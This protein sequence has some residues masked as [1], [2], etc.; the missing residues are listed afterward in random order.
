MIVQ[1]NIL[2][3]EPEIE[4][5][6]RSQ[7]GLYPPENQLKDKTLAEWWSANKARGLATIQI[8]AIDTT[9][10]FMKDVDGATALPWHAAADRLPI[11]EFDRLRDKN[12]RT[13]Q[14]IRNLIATTGKPYAAKS[15]DRRM[16]YLFGLPWTGRKHNN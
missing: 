7:F 9:I 13:L 2:C 5:I 12:L 1:R 4:V 6:T 16:T 8:E 11:K 14:A 10:G 15:L 3:F